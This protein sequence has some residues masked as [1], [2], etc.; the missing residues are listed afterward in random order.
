[1]QIL[2]SLPDLLNQNAQGSSCNRVL[3]RIPG[4]LMPAATL[5]GSP[6]SLQP[7]SHPHEAWFPLCPAPAP[8]ETSPALAASL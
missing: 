8:S 3:R 1:M 2:S 4:D 6:S 5:P 7:L